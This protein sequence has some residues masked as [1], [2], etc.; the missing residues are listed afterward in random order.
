M[1]CDRS[2]GTFR[3]RTVEKCDIG[4]LVFRAFGGDGVAFRGGAGRVSWQRGFGV[5]AH[6]RLDPLLIKG[7]PCSDGRTRVR[8]QGGGRG[9]RRGVCRFAVRVRAIAITSAIV[10]SVCV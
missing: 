5:A 4:S 10:H 2:F 8:G 3:E 9:G 6:P 1:L 7:A